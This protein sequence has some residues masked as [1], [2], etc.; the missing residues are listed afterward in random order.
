MTGSIS[1]RS[2]LFL[3]GRVLYTING[4]FASVLGVARCG[5]RSAFYLVNLA[6]RLKLFA[7]DRMSNSFLCF[8]DDL[9][10]GAFSV[11]LFHNSPLKN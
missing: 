6:F 10:R 11:F 5:V 7:A 1:R 9:I 8:A 3:A 4:F 2:A